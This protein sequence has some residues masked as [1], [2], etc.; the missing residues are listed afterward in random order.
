MA[1]AGGEH[2]LLASPGSYTIRLRAWADSQALLRIGCGSR[3][4]TR[5]VAYNTLYGVRV[6]RL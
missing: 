4:C 3:G 5:L 1:H 2:A 6:L